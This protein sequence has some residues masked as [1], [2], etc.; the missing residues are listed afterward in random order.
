MGQSREKAFDINDKIN[1]CRNLW[2]D[3]MMQMQENNLGVE[4][5][6]TPEYYAVLDRLNKSIIV[7][8]QFKVSWQ[9][10]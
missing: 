4:D 3:L 7:L 8:D 5:L 10:L 1:F 6:S 9:I 2:I